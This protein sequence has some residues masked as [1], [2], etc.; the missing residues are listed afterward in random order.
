MAP[1]NGSILAT[2]SWDIAD[3][4]IN[5]GHGVKGLSEMGLKSLQK[6]FHQRVEERFS[7]KKILGQIVNHG[8]PL[9]VLD[10]IKEVF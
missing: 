5:K 10:K 3:F 8:V 9:E 7:E 6:Q 1:T 2:E 4:V